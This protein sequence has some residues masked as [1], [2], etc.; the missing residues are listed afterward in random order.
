M[1]AIETSIFERPQGCKGSQLQATEFG[2]GS[3]IG[4]IR[5]SVV[6]CTTCGKK[7][8][9]F[10]GISRSCPARSFVHTLKGDAACT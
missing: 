2:F 7:I 3:M 10:R 5:I 4:P 1:S 9:Q 8:L 6:A